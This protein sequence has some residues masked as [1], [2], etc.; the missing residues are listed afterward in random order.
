MCVCIHS[1]CDW[2][3]L[4]H[5][6]LFA[7]PWTIQYMEFSMDNGEKKKNRY[8]SISD[9]GDLPDSSL[10]TAEYCIPC[11][12]HVWGF[13]KWHSGKQSV[14]Q[15]RRR[16]GHGFDPWVG[17][18]PW[19]RKWQP[20]PVFLSGEFHRQRSLVG[21]SSEGHTEWDITEAT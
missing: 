2:K 1:E 7:T 13:H 4:N 18:I 10:L 3:S 21:Y 19:S 17:K 8:L 5:V 6:R 16:R 11:R 12:S 14:C 20:T 9:C 15:F